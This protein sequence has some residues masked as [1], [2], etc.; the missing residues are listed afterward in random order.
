MRFWF[1]IAINLHL[2]RM[3][4]KGEGIGRDYEGRVKSGREET[5]LSF[6]GCFVVFAAG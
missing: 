6:P 4:N 2:G 5:R 3:L 1:T